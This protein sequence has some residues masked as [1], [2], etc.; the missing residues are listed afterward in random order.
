MNPFR[1]LHALTR[2][3]ITYFER[4]LTSAG[5]TFI[6]YSVMVGLPVYPEFW[7]VFLLG[8]IFLA[9]ILSPGTA[10]VL[11]VTALILPLYTISIY[12]TVLY[13]A[14][15]LLFHRVF[16]NNL[17]A[18]VLVV[19]TPILATFKLAW[20][21][22]LLAGTW[23]GV[24]SGGWMG[25]LAALWGMT[26]AGMAGLN[27]DWLAIMG[28]Q[29][30][31]DGLVERFAGLD[32]LE[33]LYQL[34]Q[35]LAAN[36]TLLLYHLLQI[37]LWGLVGALVGKFVDHERVRRK[38]WGSLY[39]TFMAGLVL[40]GAHLT[41][42]VWLGQIDSINA[43]SASLF[44]P[45]LAAGAVVGVLDI[46]RNW[47]EHPMPDF[48]LKW[49]PKKKPASVQAETDAGVPVPEKFPEWDDDK[50]DSDDIIMLEID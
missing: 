17:G 7:D 25:V 23:W 44:M 11:A 32:S 38:I 4:A 35:P 5:L 1:S 45:A 28:Q 6:V 22:P 37:I 41:I 39:I 20:L 46:L 12:L 16:I 2:R 29:P 21:V 27:P 49:K 24:S 33:T 42:G 8:A 48:P 36:T 26:A 30:Q 3:N 43:M 40:L 14:V 9:G 15:T 10:Y 18:T 31:F 50:K 19:G 13:L 34:I 47:I